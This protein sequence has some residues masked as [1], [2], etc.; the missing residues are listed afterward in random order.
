MNFFFPYTSPLFIILLNCLIW[1]FS[2]G[3]C[4]HDL[5]Y[6]A[7]SRDCCNILKIPIKERNQELCQS[8]ANLIIIIIMFFV[9][10]PASPNKQLIYTAV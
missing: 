3:N 6:N 10:P 2:Y 4:I 5:C 1:Y 7:A 8:G 9:N